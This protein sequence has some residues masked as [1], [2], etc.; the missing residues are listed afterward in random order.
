LLHVRAGDFQRVAPATG[1]LAWTLGILAVAAAVAAWRRSVPAA[2]AAFALPPL[3]LLTI[4]FGSARAYA[5]SSS[6]RRLAEHLPALPP[7][8]EVACLQCLPNGL[9]FYLR[10][11]VTV[12]TRDGSETTSN[13]VVFLLRRVTPWPDG[14][15]PLAALGEWLGTRR[16]SV[17]LLADASGRGRLDSIALPRSAAVDALTEGWWG[18]LLPAP[19]GR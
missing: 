6:A 11:T 4:G 7:A 15:V 17:Y 13:Y 14:V 10:R 16:G 9:P 18:A 8:S 2:C 12:V 3:L 1:T 5:E 19:G